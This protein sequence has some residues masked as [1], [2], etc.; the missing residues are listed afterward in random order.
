MN[1]RQN[2][3][4]RRKCAFPFFKRGNTEG[5]Y[6]HTFIGQISKSFLNSPSYFA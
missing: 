6:L 2:K 3:I 4:Q 1:R 5:G